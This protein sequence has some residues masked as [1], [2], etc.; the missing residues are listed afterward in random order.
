M[1]TPFGLSG[2]L[3]CITSLAFGWFVYLKGHSPLLNR[4][5][6]LFSI[7]V[8]LWGL[9][10]LWIGQSASPEESVW[11]WRLAFMT[12][13][14]WIAP[15]FYHFVC[16]FCELSRPRTLA[17]LYLSTA[18]I[19]PVILTPWFFDGVR[20][21]F[22]SFYY[23]TPG[24]VF[25]LFFLWWSGIVVYAHLELV[26]AFRHARGH[27][28]HQ[29]QY[30]FLATAIGYTGGSL[31][32]LPIFGIDLYPYGNFAIV[33]YPLIMT[34]AILKFRLM[35]CT[36]FMER[37]LSYLLLV[38]LI[39]AP[40]LAFFIHTQKLYFSQWNLEFSLLHVVVVV[41]TAM[42][43][44]R[45]KL[46]TDAAIGRTLFP[47]RHNMVETLLA[48]SRRLI[49][50]LDLQ[51]L[52]KEIV[53]SFVN[54]LEMRSAALYLYDQNRGGYIR[55]AL[56][57]VPS[58]DT[59]AVWC[60]V[61]NPLIQILSRSRDILL[62]EEF[63]HT[64][65]E[66]TTPQVLRTLESLRADVCLPFISSDRLIGFC[67]LESTAGRWLA[68]RDNLDLLSTMAHY[69]G[70]A[71]TNAQ[72]YHDLHRSQLL[73]LRTD[74]LDSLETMAAGFAHEIRNPLTSIKTFVQLIPERLSDPQF[75]S[76]FRAT[77]SEDI[78]RIE[79]LIQEILDYARYQT[80]RLSTE[81]LN[82]IVSSSLSFV[83]IQGLMKHIAIHTHLDE[84]L[85]SMLVDRQ[86]FRQVLLNL[87]INALDALAEGGQLTV[88]TH[89]FT[90]LETQWIAIDISDTGH[91]IAPANLPHIFDPFYTTKH[92]STEREGTGLG[93]AIVHQIISEHH[94]TIEVTSEVGQGTCFRI[95]LPTQ[96]PASSQHRVA[97]S[98]DDRS[99][100]VP[101]Q[102]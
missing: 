15:T 65:E 9:G 21:R 37:G 16:V 54:I 86:Q 68:S 17:L 64:Q 57:G 73:M 69:A 91:G 1:M 93:L 71:L 102:T 3:T 89:A 31:D 55:F 34:Y 7:S 45:L 30:F 28:R 77:V 59:E 42:V 19:A 22:D 33:L 41:V 40:S 24:P 70:I 92:A 8:S 75:T 46:G 5:W 43:A 6:L 99:T 66:P 82:E 20:Y 100:S 26:R 39:A 101:M 58:R 96:P 79:R 32:Y 14:V 47:S 52:A 61:T 87:F 98:G 49:T 29:I 76:D 23:A 27:H 11:A 74:R 12:G 94:G 2:L 72:L 18:C 67:T 60:P 56:S 62:L 50:I 53:G 85:P 10:A 4:R 88:S 36:V 81:H 35:D 63:V 83:H 78:G 97:V 44:Y 80:P 84:D 95:H 48:F 38:I 25:P 51:L 13:V 90:K